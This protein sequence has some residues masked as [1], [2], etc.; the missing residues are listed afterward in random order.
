MKLLRYL[1]V[2]HLPF[3]SIHELGYYD[4]AAT[5]D[6]ILHIT[7]QKQLYYVGHSQGGSV[8]FILNSMRPEYN[9]RFRLMVAL[10]PA[11]NVTNTKHVPV[12]IAEYFQKICVNPI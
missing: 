1:I 7:N 9:K 8:F 3:I 10:A 4:L 5:V 12:K 6:Y 2:K 11:V